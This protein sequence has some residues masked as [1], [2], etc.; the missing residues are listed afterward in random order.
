MDA[1][2]SPTREARVH[3]RHELRTLTY[4]TLDQANGGIVRNL[5][6][7]GIGVQVVAA[8]RPGQQLRVRFELRSPRLRVETRGEVMWAT[9]SGQCG[10]RLLDLPPR[11]ARQIN[12]W[13]FG[14]LLD[15]AALQTDC[16][17]SM[18]IES[19]FIESRFIE[20]RSVESRSAESRLR[21]SSVREMRPAVSPVLP[22]PVPAGEG[23]AKEDDVAEEDD[24]LM[25]SAA[26]VMVIELKARPEPVLDPDHD[27]QED[28]NPD[29]SL[30]SVHAPA[31]E[32]IAFEAAAGEVA[33]ETPAESDWLSQPLSGNSLAWTVNALAVTAALLLFAL[34]FLIVTRELPEWP[35]AMIG[36][37]A[38]F[39]VCFYWG[40]FKLFGGISPGARLARLAVSDSEGE[41]E[42]DARFR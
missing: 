39:V 15:G 41:K 17:R 35:F 24:G 33:W 26:P 40:F 1:G 22:R 6:D 10:I 20:S 4:V 31:S 12:E 5:T 38:A 36:G 34:V 27:N 23:V 16:D 30:L 11:M 2:L 19:R 25:V 7:E 13:I 29:D 37:A 42:I 8:V 32:A 28:V 21:E 14:N 9:S 18:F 3:H